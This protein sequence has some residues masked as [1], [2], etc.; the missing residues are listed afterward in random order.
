MDHGLRPP[1]A[2]RLGRHG[3]ALLLAAA[4]ALASAALDE[5]AVAAQLQA[6]AARVQQLEGAAA[7]RDSLAD[8]VAA[9]EA[10]NTRLR[11]QTSA[12]TPAATPSVVTLDRKLKVLERKLEVE[13]ELAA[14]AAKAQPEFEIGK[15]GFVMKSPD[16][17]FRLQFR[18]FLQVDTNNFISDDGGVLN[19]RFTLRRARLMFDG[20][21]FKYIDYRY[22][23]DF[24]RG[25][26]TMF[27]AQIDVHYFP[28]ASFT[29]G[30]F[31]PPVGLERLQGAPNLLFVERAFPTALVPNRDTGFMLHGQFEKPGYTLAYTAPPVFRSFF[32]YQIGVFSGAGDFGNRN[33]EGDT[34]D[35]KEFAGRLFMHPFLHSGVEPLEGLGVG[36]AGTWSDQARGAVRGFDSPGQNAMFDY[37]S[38]VF[39]DGEHYRLAPQAYW[40]WG[41]FGAMAEWT[42]SSQQLARTVGART[43]SDR[44]TN[45]AWQLAGSWMLTGEDAAYYGVRPRHIVLGDPTGI[46]VNRPFNP[47]A[48]NWGAWQIAARFS[49]IDIDDVTFTQYADPDRSVSAAR[50]WAL[51]LN[52]YLNDFI[53]VMANY[54]HTDFDGGAARG[55][56]RPDE[57]AV[58]TRIQYA[59]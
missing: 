55:R 54:E 1:H 42:E 59:F 39:V 9:L 33:D 8:R 27:D 22:A 5:A 53:K 21:L 36:F 17:A 15:T 10:E 43:V 50:A 46:S 19:D 58:L 48:G 16:D 41:P 25:R 49:A 35:Q 20:T 3:V 23:P 32:T 24:G 26:F 40:Y 44:Q 11:Q 2:G 14:E 45:R 51:G 6:L 31:R 18:S 4:P 34:D 7:E 28:K 38:N 57:H 56:D 37:R 47:G 29:A 52:W 30:K 12:S 13:K